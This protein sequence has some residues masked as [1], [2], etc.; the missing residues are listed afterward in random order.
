MQLITLSWQDLT[1][2]IVR[3]DHL[4]QQNGK[5]TTLVALQR[6]G[7][8]PAVMLAHRFEV[9]NLLSLDLRSTID[10]SVNAKKTQPRLHHASLP[11]LDTEDVLLVD[12]IAGTGKTLRFAQRLVSDHS[13]A[14]LR[15]LVCL[16]NRLNWDPDNPVSP[17]DAITYT[18]R[19]VE[20]WVTFPWEIST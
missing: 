11:P 20:G 4:V 10:D 12:D 14:R 7:L 18:G 17:P 1:E 19:L 9:R 3:L 16:V 13:P 8:V 6:G 15:S 2:I 5:P